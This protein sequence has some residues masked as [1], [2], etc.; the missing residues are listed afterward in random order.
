MAT[1]IERQQ[2]LFDSAKVDLTVRF[3][4]LGIAGK[5]V[6]EKVALR[7]VGVVVKRFYVAG[8]ERVG[9]VGCENLLTIEA[10]AETQDR[11]VRVVV[12]IL[13]R[14]LDHEEEFTYRIFQI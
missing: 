4:R 6:H 7:K 5:G 9:R 8:V 2:N 14:G 1:T 13:I 3:W 12:G 10:Q 11:V